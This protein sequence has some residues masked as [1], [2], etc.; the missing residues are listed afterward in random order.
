[1]CGFAPSHTIRPDSSA[2]KPRWIKLRMKF[3]DWESPRLITHRTFPA[4]GLS[5]PVSSRAE[6]RRNEFR[7]RVAAY[8]MPITKGSLAVYTRTY[9]EAG[10]KPS[11]R[12]ILAGSG[13]PGKGVAEQSAN[14]QLAAGTDVGRALV[15][16][17]RC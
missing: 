2:L 12:Q 8:P 17:R 13:L 6:Y 15:E 9:S 3:P 16:M 1:M 7:S 10:S 5:V 14:A 4:S 11:F